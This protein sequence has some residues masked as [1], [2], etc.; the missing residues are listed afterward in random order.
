MK[1]HIFLISFV[2]VAIAC[3]VCIKESNAAGCC[4]AS[5]K[6]VK[7]CSIENLIVKVADRQLRELKDVQ[8]IRDEQGR[9]KKYVPPE[10]VEWQYAWGVTL[11]G[12]LRTSETLGEEKY[13]DF[14]VRHNENAARHYDHLRG[15]LRYSEKYVSDPG[16][17]Y[18]MRLTMLDDCGSMGSQILEGILRGNAQVTPEVSEAVA[19]I[20]DYIF[21]KQSRLPDGSFWRPGK[22]AAVWNDDLYMSVPFLVRYAEYSGRQEYLDDAAR[23]IINFAGYTQDKDGL[24]FHAYFPDQR[25]TSPYKWCRANGWTILSIVEFLSA[26]GQNHKDGDKILS[27]YKKHAEGLKRCQADSGLWRQVLDHPELWEETSSTAMFVYAIAR[28][29][30][31][32]WLDKSYLQVALKGYEGLKKNITDEGAILNV[33]QGTGIGQT[34]EYY[35]D[36]D[37]PFDDAH[38]P[39]PVLLALTELKIACEKQQITLQ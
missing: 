38:G 9:L 19:V 21:R 12:L 8:Y 34:L 37:K 10:G 1:R 17:K 2:L 20:G 14:V 26:N 7:N 39:G 23:Q 18:L 11:Y 16:M 35:I 25:K 27:I 3:S 4:A 22:E 15:K 28:G 24:F 32:G 29:V 30:N 36:R 6:S 13:R 5:A 33:C 31:R